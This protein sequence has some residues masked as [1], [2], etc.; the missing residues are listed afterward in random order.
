MGI[1]ALGGGVSSVGES[2]S[3][4]RSVPRRGVV[5]WG[6]G[7]DPLP[8]LVARVRVY[9]LECVPLGIVK[10]SNINLSSLWT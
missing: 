10:S 8:F 4:G 2:S 6:E 9:P 3:G 7:S 1:V 5:L